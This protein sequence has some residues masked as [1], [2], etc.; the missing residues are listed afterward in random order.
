MVMFCSDVFPKGVDTPQFCFPRHRNAKPCVFQIGIKIQQI[1]SLGKEQELM[2]W[3][4]TD[5]CKYLVS[6]FRLPSGQIAHAGKKKVLR[7]FLFHHLELTWKEFRVSEV[8]NHM[9][10]LHIFAFISIFTPHYTSDYYIHFLNLIFH[11]NTHY[12]C[13]SS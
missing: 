5:L 4:F 11:T 12:F 1:R 3:I 6:P 7:T 13:P 9:P 8:I 2:L 10:S